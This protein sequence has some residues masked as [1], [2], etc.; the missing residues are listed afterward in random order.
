MDKKHGEI[1]IYHTCTFS[2]AS[3]LTVF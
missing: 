1:E 3:S 2:N